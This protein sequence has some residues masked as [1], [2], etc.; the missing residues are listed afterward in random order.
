[1]SEQPD[2]NEYYEIAKVWIFKIKI[3]I[4]QSNL[5]IN[6]NFL[7]EKKLGKFITS[8][9]VINDELTRASQ[10]IFEENFWIKILAEKII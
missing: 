9:T 6:S 5:V 3:F 8:D 1:M 4:F 10:I 2:Q 7:A